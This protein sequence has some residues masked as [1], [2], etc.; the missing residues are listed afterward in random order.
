LT[1]GQV[2]TSLQAAGAS[3]QAAVLE[4]L[5]EFR[6][7]LGRSMLLI[8]HNLGVVAC[9]ADAALLM[10]RE[11]LRGRPGR[12]RHRERGRRLHPSPDRRRPSPG[13]AAV[14]ALA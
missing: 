1:T 4:L 2:R 6:R 7:E 8:T 13:E 9:I 10:N 14:T 11:D 5:Q 3:G 12:S